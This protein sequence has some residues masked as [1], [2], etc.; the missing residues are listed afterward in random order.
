MEVFLLSNQK[1][2]HDKILNTHWER[3]PQL[4]KLTENSGSQFQVYRNHEIKKMICYNPELM[5]A[6]WFTNIPSPVVDNVIMMSYL[7][8]VKIDTVETESGVV[9]NVHG[10]VGHLLLRAYFFTNPGEMNT[11]E[12]RLIE[13]FRCGK[14][15]QLIEYG[16]DISKNF[17]KTVFFGENSII[18]RDLQESFCLLRRSVDIAHNVAMCTPILQQGP[19]PQQKEI[20]SGS[21]PSRVC[22]TQKDHEIP[23]VHNNYQHR[24]LDSSVKDC[25]FSNGLADACLQSQQCTSFQSGFDE[26]KG[27][28]G[29]AASVS[30]LQQS[31][32][33]EKSNLKHEGAGITNQNLLPSSRTVEKKD[34]QEVDILDRERNGNVASSRGGYTLASSANVTCPPRPSN[35]QMGPD[36]LP[37]TQRARS[38]TPTRAESY[39]KDTLSIFR[40]A[41]EVSSCAAKDDNCGIRRK[42]FASAASVARTKTVLLLGAKGSGK[43]CL[44]NAVANFIMGAKSDSEKW[45]VSDEAIK[46]G[47]FSSTENITG[48]TFVIKEKESEDLA[49][50]LID[51]PGLND[52]SGNEVRDHV[53]SLKT[54][55]A[56]AAHKKL[57]IHAIAL[58]VQAH[59]VRLT[60]SERL[61]MDHLKT[62]FGQDVSDHVVHLITF[63]DN[64]SKPPVVEALD[65]YGITTTHCFKF[66]N[67]VFCGSSEEDEKELDRVYWKTSHKSWKKCWKVVK[68]LSPLKTNAMKSVQ[69][70]M[71]ETNVRETVVQELH[72]EMKYFLGLCK[73]APLN[74]IEEQRRK[75]WNLASVVFRMQQETDRVRCTSLAVLVEKKYRECKGKYSGNLEDLCLLMTGIPTTLFKAAIT[76]LEVNMRLVLSIQDAARKIKQPKGR[77]KKAIAM[78][79]SSNEEGELLAE[80]ILIVTENYVVQTAYESVVQLAEHHNCAPGQLSGHSFLRILEE[81]GPSNIHWMVTKLLQHECSQ[82]KTTI[83]YKGGHK[84]KRH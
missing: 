72:G 44:V 4:P 63:A 53:E 45:T 26:R 3:I 15:N 77:I 83:S 35:T 33:N 74:Q 2:A 17:K 31:E 62:L 16:H 84:T 1:M 76:I 34:R 51:T 14:E 28:N 5:R 78:L 82:M 29:N 22:G 8:P 65:Q 24:D 52:S 49:L 80:D 43:T 20:S 48:Y 68:D 58:V 9:Q 73:K 55:L 75:V 57:E 18:C 66:N 64:Q 46:T 13:S 38:P 32:T 25:L 10:F 23:R 69:K 11:V 42:F 71:Y 59:L 21:F 56:N 47:G 41:E 12:K 79:M 36:A 67:S 30:R 54:F 70:E 19:F 27:S 7:K 40:Q 39:G 60:S 37:S 6:P 81:R 61:V 50:T